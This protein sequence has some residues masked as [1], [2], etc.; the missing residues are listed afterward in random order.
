MP[1]SARALAV[2]EMTGE[3]RQRPAEQRA[4]VGPQAEKHN[5]VSGSGWVM[6]CILFQLAKWHLE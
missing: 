2:R 6:F 5:E 4:K 3:K 1:T